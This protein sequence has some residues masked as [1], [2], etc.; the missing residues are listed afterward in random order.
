MLDYETTM[1]LGQATYQDAIDALTAAGLPTEFTQTGGMNAALLVTLEAGWT[2]LIT[3]ADESLAW[4]RDEHQGWGVGLYEP[5][6]EDGSHECVA[7]AT[8]EDG[9]VTE[10]LGLV[11]KILAE[12]TRAARGR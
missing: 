11:R 4:Y 5:D 3:D 1:K 2:V 12:H 9:A 6:D 10:L 7:F 8:T